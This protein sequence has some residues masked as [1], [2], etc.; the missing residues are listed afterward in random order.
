MPAAQFKYIGHLHGCPAPVPTGMITLKGVKGGSPLNERFE[1]QVEPGEVFDIPEDW[2]V[3]IK[4]L[5][6]QR[7]PFKRAI[8]LYERVA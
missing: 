1:M 8:K 6:E 2:T 7:H 5:E 3:A 4:G